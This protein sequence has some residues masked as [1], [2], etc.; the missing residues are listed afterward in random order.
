MSMRKYQKGI[1][2][3]GVEAHI[4][5]QALERLDASYFK[6]A[7]ETRKNLLKRLKAKF[8]ADKKRMGEKQ[9]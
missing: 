5:I 9:E 7:D 3:D 6:D 8:L 1:K 4:M 2:L